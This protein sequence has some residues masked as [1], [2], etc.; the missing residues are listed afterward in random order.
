MKIPKNAIW[1]T[2]ICAGLYLLI[3]LTIYV[4]FYHVF[5]RPFMQELPIEVRTKIQDTKDIEHLR[6]ITLLLESRVRSDQR[7]LNDLF[8]EAIQLI[9]ILNI[10]AS[11][12][13]LTNLGYWLKFIRGQNGEYVPWWLRLL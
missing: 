8:D 4:A 1:H 10:M 11:V 13:F 6:E 12:V 2:S 5:P 7:S 9:I 3:A